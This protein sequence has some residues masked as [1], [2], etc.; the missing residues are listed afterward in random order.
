ML[1][2]TE[3]EK[4]AISTR[5]LVRRLGRP[6]EIAKAILYLSSDDAGYITGEVLRINGGSL[7]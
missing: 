5:P 7:I 3:E 2:T 1:A 4:Q 6:E